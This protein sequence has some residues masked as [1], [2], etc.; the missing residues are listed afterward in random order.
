L[1]AKDIIILLQQRHKNDVCVEQCKIHVSWNSGK[2]NVPNSGWKKLC[3]KRWQE[4]P[5]TSEQSWYW[6]TAWKKAYKAESPIIDLWV[7]PRKWKMGG[8]I[9]YEV[10]VNRNDLR[11]DHKFP[12]YWST[13]NLFYFVI[14]NKLVTQAEMES[15]PS[16][17]GFLETTKNH[18]SLRIRKK[19]IYMQQEIDSNIYRYI[20]MW[21]TK[22]VGSRFRE[23]N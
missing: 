21:R 4:S 14:P 12:D 20:L 19:P 6:H 13:C 23:F 15:Y 9:C 17:V 22:I 1:K 2:I 7:L 8:P 3:Y 11:N 10:K 18:K 16:N 5:R